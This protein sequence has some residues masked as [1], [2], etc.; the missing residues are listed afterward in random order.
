VGPY[1]SE[2]FSLSRWAVA[3]LI[4]AVVVS[5]SSCSR[6]GNPGTA[7]E[8]CATPPPG[9]GPGA[10]GTLQLP[11]NGRTVC[12]SVG[13]ELTIFLKAPSLDSALWGPIEASDPAVLEPGNLGI[14]TLVRGITGGIFVARRVGTARL[15]SERPSCA[16]APPPASSTSVTCTSVVSWSATVVVTDRGS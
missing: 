16:P 3:V 7:H 1:G 11:D 12:L 10:A 5:G 4:A 2:P 13:K 8:R 15:T 14:M 6:A 9:I